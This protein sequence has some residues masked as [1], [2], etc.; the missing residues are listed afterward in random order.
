MEKEVI[1]SFG[2]GLVEESL[3]LSK[4]AKSYIADVITEVGSVLADVKFNKKTLKIEG[5]TDTA[6][7]IIEELPTITLHGRHGDVEVSLVGIEHSASGFDC[8]TIYYV[9]KDWDYEV[10]GK[11]NM[12]DISSA[13]YLTLVEFIADNV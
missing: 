11:C 2:K 9:D 12:Y 7:D 6:Y 13:D 1:K 3:M 4:R 10:V 5:D 8:F